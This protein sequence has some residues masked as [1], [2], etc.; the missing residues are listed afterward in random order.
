[1]G[2]DIILTGIS[3]FL[4]WGGLIWNTLRDIKYKTISFVPVIFM[5]SGGILIHILQGEIWEPRIWCSFIPGVVC[6]M[7]A[8]LS[9]GEIGMGDGW[10]LLAMGALV[11]Y[12]ILFHSCILAMVLAAVVA[13]ILFVVFHKNK[14][15]TIPFI[16]FLAA[17]YLWGRF[18][19]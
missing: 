14:K 17:G 8:F 15:Y 9:R 16:P 7:I 19:F 3:E 2:T 13:G 12:Q 11:E 18:V 5:F 6:I 10:M 1:M 4:I